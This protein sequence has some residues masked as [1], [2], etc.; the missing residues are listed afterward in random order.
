MKY[1]Y[2]VHVSEE[3]EVML[4]LKVEDLAMIEN[5]MR[6]FAAK[7]LIDIE[8][9][10]VHSGQ[11]YEYDVFDLWLSAMRP[12]TEKEVAHRKAAARK[13]RAEV[14]QREQKEYERLK[15]KFEK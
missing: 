15:K 12:P 1:D 11:Q 3:L 9:I 8:D 4:P 5:A 7:Y 6:N 2:K 14:K 10:E 13:A